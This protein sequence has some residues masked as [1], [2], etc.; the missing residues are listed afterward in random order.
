MLNKKSVKDI[1][2]GS[3]RVL[4]RCDFNVPLDRETKSKI[5]SDKRIVE[6]LK[7]IEYLVN[8]GAKVILCSHIGKTGQNISLK[9]VAVRLEEL[10]GKKILFLDDCIGENVKN[11]VNNMSPGDIVLLENLRMHE[12]EEQNDDAFAKELASLA[13]V[14]VND[15]FGTAHRAH[16]STYGVT[17]YLPAVCGFLIEK[18]LLALDKGINEPVRP[19]LAIIGG[20]K[21]SS[22]IS[23][24]TNLLDKVDTMMIGGAMVYTFQKALGNNVGKSLVEDDKI[25][26]ALE[27]MKK[28][29]EKGVKFL[30]PIDNVVANE[31]SENS[32]YQNAR[33]GEIPEDMAGVDIGEETIKMFTEEILRA[34]TVVWNGPVGV[35]EIPAFEKGTKAIAFALAESDAVTIIGGGDS[36]AAIEK[37]GLEDKMTHVST[38]GGASLEFMEGKDLPGIVALEDK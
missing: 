19:L 35:F 37:F 3:K 16:A 22:K 27:I 33:I 10:L 21:V 29:E 34:G 13:D 12:E 1:E 4:V 38:G 28:A 20:A 36:A 5:T 18:E 30:M 6:S 8:A 26:T 17:K 7:T 23:V 31:I 2:V 25:D 15:A 32:N 11:A 9:P 24:L 14:F